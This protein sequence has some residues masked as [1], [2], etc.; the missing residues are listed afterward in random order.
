MASPI[1]YTFGR[2][3]VDLYGVETGIPF[4]AVE[5]FKKY[6]GGSAANT[7][8]G[9]ARL[10]L[11]V[12]LISRVGPDRFGTYLLRTLADEGVNTDMISRDPILPTGL[13]FAAMRPPEDSEVVFYGN[14]NAN[15]AVGV[16]DLNLEAIGAARYLVLGGTA[17]ATSSTREAALIALEH[18][19]RAGGINILDVDWRSNYW[20][21]QATAEFYYRLA[22]ERTDMVLANAPELDFVGVAGDALAS[23]ER[24]WD[25]GVHTVIAKQGA[26]GVRMLTA[27]QDIT[28]AACSVP[29]VNTLGAGDGFA[30]GFVAGL[31]Q[32]LSMT[33]VLRFAAATAG[34]V[35][36]RHSCSAAMPSRAEVQALLDRDGVEDGGMK[37]EVR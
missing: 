19:R 27:E 20:D 29:V 32:G 37:E 9:L 4:E 2:A 31:E 25:L 12:G 30:A 13:A 6:V 24:L 14:P 36:S 16:D 15:G 26:Q 11:S 33:Q 28:V 21:H 23:A 1:V 8:V 18:H 34:I 22:L 3:I 5:Q 10:G 17:L 7:A 35:V